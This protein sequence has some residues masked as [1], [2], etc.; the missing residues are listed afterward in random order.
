[1][2]ARH[3]SGSRAVNGE[4][5]IRRRNSTAFRFNDAGEDVARAPSACAVSP[6]P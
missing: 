5:A 1:M 6:R 4:V 3:V 2:T